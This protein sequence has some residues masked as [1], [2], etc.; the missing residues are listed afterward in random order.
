[1]WQWGQ[2]RDQRLPWQTRQVA[3][4]LL[5]AAVAGGLLLARSWGWLQQAELVAYDWLIRARSTPPLRDRVV[6]VGVDEPDIQFLKVWPARDRDLAQLLETL[7]AARPVAI[8][9]DIYRDLPLPPGKEHLEEIFQNS[10]VPIVGIRLMPDS[11]KKGILPAPALA[12]YQQI[13]FNNIIIDPDRLVRR[14]ILYWWHTDSKTRQ[15]QMHQSFAFV[16]AQLYLQKRQVTLTK[17]EDPKQLQLGRLRLSP[18]DPNSGGYQGIDAGGYQILADWRGP[19]RTVPVVWW[20]D[21]V[22]GK[23]SPAQL[24]GRI[25]VIGAMT[26]SLKDYAYTPYSNQGRDSAQPIFGAELQA[27]AIEQLLESA[28]EGRPP[29]RTWPDWVEQVWILLWTAAGA[30][31]VKRSRSIGQAAFHLA[32]ALGAIGSFTGLS[33]GWGWWIPIVPVA[34]GTL[35]SAGGLWLL[36]FQRQQEQTRST[37]FFQQV[38][39][40]IPEPLF[41]KDQNRRW[42]AVNP[43]FCNFT[44]LTTT[45]LL[46]K[47]AEDVFSPEL[48]AALTAE[49]QRAIDQL[50]PAETQFAWPD[51]FGRERM[52]STKRT[53]HRDRAGNQFLVGVMRDITEQCRAEAELRRTAAE[54]RDYTQQLELAHDV[55]QYQARHDGLTGLVNRKYFY[56]RLDVALQ[57]ARQ[58]RFM[59]AVLYLDLD[60]FKAV[61]DTLGHRAGD[62]LLI[63]CAQRLTQ[64]LRG[65][66]T[67]AR[68]GGDEFVALLPAIPQGDVAARVAEK[69]L[70]AVSK[71]YR[72]EGCDC[73]ITVSIGV[74]LFPDDAETADQLIE[75]AD[76]A[77]FAAKGMGKNAFC[78]YGEPPAQ[79]DRVLRG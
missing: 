9:L 5:V 26:E 75:Y 71:P 21:V 43:A 33:L 61:N 10:P 73:Q 34:M 18:I 14:H 46:G 22:Q 29:I 30:I 27:Q 50:G 7:V 12:R 42:I 62:L 69:L 67:I 8:G 28:I 66:D 31:A 56:E 6:I 37:L 17:T 40:A 44:G 79:P 1:M 15:R 35:A 2:W 63:E 38:L 76:S 77:M 13:G 68:F 48:A 47:R 78:L 3:D 45:D 59:S 64:N 51:P 70:A 25:V 74:A 58:D 55:L 53:L 36:A 49:D 19:S 23:V 41:V 39:A 16:L 57:Q 52:V 65:S 4:V 11:E 60:G 32:L 72:V 20:R 54:L 24:S